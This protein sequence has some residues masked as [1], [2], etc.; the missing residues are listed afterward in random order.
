MKK[1]TRICWQ[2]GGGER[3]P[4]PAGWQMA[5]LW[6]EHH[7]VGVPSPRGRRVCFSGRLVRERVPVFG[8]I[9]VGVLCFE[10]ARV[11]RLRCRRS[12]SPS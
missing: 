6:M 3:S 11:I 10:G 9:D 7:S 4:R 5:G 8:L 12:D 1:R 2:G